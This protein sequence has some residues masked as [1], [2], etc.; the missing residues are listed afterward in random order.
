MSKRHPRPAVPRHIEVYEDDWK[1][2]QEMFRGTRL[3][4]SAAIRE[5]ISKRV[6][7]LREKEVRRHDEAPMPEGRLPLLDSIFAMEEK[8]Q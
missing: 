3:S 4:V 8:T 2:L 1:F 6:K 5:I 7:E